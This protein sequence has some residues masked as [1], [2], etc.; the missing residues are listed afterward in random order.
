M[1]LLELSEREAEA[2]ISALLS[3]I[4]DMETGEIISEG[5]IKELTQKLSCLENPNISESEADE[6]G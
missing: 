1:I 3:K 2:V 6:N 5:K 4:L